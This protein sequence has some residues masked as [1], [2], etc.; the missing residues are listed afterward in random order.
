MDRPELALL[1]VGIALIAIGTAR[2]RAPWARYQTLRA[3]EANVAR[4]EAWRGGVRDPGPTGASVAMDLLRTRI[5]NAA[6]IAVAGF[7]IVFVAFLL[8]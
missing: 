6:L 5:R 2:A 4:Y 8:S 1:V 3:Q 7:V